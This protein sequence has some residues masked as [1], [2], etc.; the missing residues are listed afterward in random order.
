MMNSFFIRYIPLLL[1]LIRPLCPVVAQSTGYNV[2]G[3]RPL[4][5][6]PSLFINGQ[7]YPP[8]FYMSY[9]GEEQYYR[10]A[11]ATGIHLYSLPCYLGDR[12][13]NTESG[14]GPFRKPLWTGVNQYDFSA[15]REDFE[16]LLLADPAA[17]VIVRLH[18]DPPL[19]WENAHPDADCRLPDGST[20]RQCFA[21]EKWK[22][23]T[24]RVLKDVTEWLL[25]S[26]YAAQLIG[27]H[28]AAGGTEEWVYHYHQ[29]FYDENPTRTQAFRRW[30][31]RRYAGSN[32]ALRKAWGQTNVSFQTAQ[33][34]DIS[35]KNS[36]PAWRKQGDEEDV[37]DTYRFHAETLA[38]DIAYFCKIVKETSHRR[39]L[40]GA[41]YGYHYFITDPRKGHGA[42]A[43]LLR[44][45]DL[46]YL[47]SPN[48]YNRVMGEDWPPMAAVQSIQLHGK[49]WLAENDTRTSITTLLKDR[50]PDV[51]PPGKRYDGGVW[52]G[53]PDMDAS[54]ALLKKNL[55]RMLTGS[56]G[57]WWFDMWGG[58]FS[59]PRLLEVFEQEQALWEK[60]R[61][62]AAPEMN[63]QVCV[64]ADGEFCFRDASNG[65]LA[66]QVLGNS[67]PLGKTGAPYD[68][69][70]R[71]DMEKLPGNRYKVIWLLGTSALTPREKA[72]IKKA[73]CRRPDIADGWRRHMG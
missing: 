31:Q 7:A 35:G 54:V 27:I 40:T 64:I 18:L 29:Y 20:F 3:V 43:K 50:A 24:G 10:E 13:I 47:S 14:I 72:F 48:A 17:K 68:L 49:L 59:D 66:A 19:W 22:Q 55:G 37:V 70:L 36:H 51:N 45:P 56:Y 11:A 46:D 67:S 60:Y 23:E 52:L 16:K 4:Q 5:G 28:V 44:C 53:P 15:I 71:E 21:S 63:A 57:G 8:F 12:G 34:A 33:P 38:D 39:L 1:L 25:S 69:F 73:R 62:A 58:W 61:P 2:A 65:Q 41:F 32:A 42:L 26:R 6:V 9:L 30:L